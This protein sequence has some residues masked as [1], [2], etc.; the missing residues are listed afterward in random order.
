MKAIQNKYSI[1][2]GLSFSFEEA[3]TL[4]F[5]QFQ[6]GVIRWARVNLRCQYTG[7]SFFRHQLVGCRKRNETSLLATGL[8]EYVTR[9]R[10]CVTWVIFESQSRIF[11]GLLHH[12]PVDRNRRLFIGLSLSNVESLRYPVCC[13]LSGLLRQCQATIL[14]PSF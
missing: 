10:R 7:I 9:T 5:S 4:L 11:F 3:K 8:C 12:A 14:T 1:V 2:S 6:E 13:I